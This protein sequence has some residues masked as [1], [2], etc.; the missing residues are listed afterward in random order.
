MTTLYLRPRELKAEKWTGSNDG[1]IR[2]LCEG[3]GP[4]GES[5]CEIK[6]KRVVVTGH[7]QEQE[8][9]YNLEV[10]TGA[11]WINVPMGWWVVQMSET[12]AMGRMSPDYVEHYCNDSPTPELSSYYQAARASQRRLERVALGIEKLALELATVR[13]EPNLGRF[14]Q[15]RIRQLLCTHPQHAL[16]YGQAQVW[17]SICFK[18]LESSEM[19]ATARE[20]MAHVITWCRCDSEKCPVHTGPNDELPAPTIVIPAI[21]ESL[22]NPE[23]A[24]ASELVTF[25][26]EERR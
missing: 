1:V 3:R 8:R 12:H 21:P 25:D 18:Q 4:Q 5:G 20:M 14:V 7:Q 10:W 15:D 17:C 23:L 13:G 6:L 19:E 16:R 9:L 22:R 11:T 26:T 2:E 24:P